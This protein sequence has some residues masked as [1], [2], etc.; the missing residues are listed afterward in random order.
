MNLKPY[1]YYESLYQKYVDERKA[2]GLKPAVRAQDFIAL[3]VFQDFGV[4]DPRN[5]ASIELL[6]QILSRPQ[7]EKDKFL[8]AIS[9]LM[10][11]FEWNS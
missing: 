1:S 6:N 8:E 11:R 7:R 4:K 5:G 10:K 3:E 2:E 9:T